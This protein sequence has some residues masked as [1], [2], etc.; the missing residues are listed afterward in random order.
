MLK[1]YPLFKMLSF[2]KIILSTFHILFLDS[3]LVGGFAY[4]QQALIPRDEFGNPDFNGY[5]NFNDSTP[6]E[7]PIEFGNKE[8][9][10]ETEFQQKLAARV[11]EGRQRVAR[12]VNLVDEVISVPTINPGAYNSFWSYYKDGFP[13]K[14]TSIIVS[15]LNGRLPQ[16]SDALV[17]LSPPHA[18][19]CNNPVTVPLKRPVRI[20]FGAIT[21]DRPED[22]GLSTRCLLFPQTTG[23]YI[24]ANSYNN[25]LQIVVTKDFAVLYSELG[26]D[27]RIVPLDDSPFL[28]QRIQTWT[29]SSRGRWD[30]DILTVETRHF[31]PQMASIFMRNKALGS[32]EDMVLIEKFSLINSD[33]L[34]YEFVLSDPST[35][36]TEIKGIVNFSRLDGIIY[37]FACHEGNYALLNMLRAARISEIQS[38]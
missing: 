4:A 29:G 8:F 22:F 18:N 27:P 17:Q 20:S 23:P 35:F 15:P 36:D 9:L 2:Q 34:A 28:D 32:A 33:S 38:N 24:K 30:G 6:F 3:V 37:E 26:N 11:E 19:G 7:R 16:T 14:R 21:C 10:S 31:H 12:E 1:I 25:N 13:N 5:W